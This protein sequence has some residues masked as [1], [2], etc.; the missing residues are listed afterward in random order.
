MTR[1]GSRSVATSAA[2]A[3][4]LAVGAD[5]VLEVEDDRVGGGQRL[6]VPVGPVGGAEQQRG[7]RQGRRSEPSYVTPLPPLAGRTGLA[8]GWPSGCRRCP[9]F[10]WHCISVVRVTTATT[11]PCW[12]RAVC[13]NVTIP[14]PGRL[15]DSR[16]SVTTVS[17]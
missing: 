16:F 4:S 13:S 7:P 8:F 14:W 3:A 11:S 10:G 12:L 9:C 6:G 5:A 1:A 17:P 15:A 2:R